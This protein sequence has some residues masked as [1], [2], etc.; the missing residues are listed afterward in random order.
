MCPL[1]SPVILCYIIFQRSFPVLCASL[2][3]G[4]AQSCREASYSHRQYH[5]PLSPEGSK[6]NRARFLFAGSRVEVFRR[7]GKRN[8][9]LLNDSLVTFCSHRKSPCGAYRSLTLHPLRQEG[10]T[11][12]ERPAASHR[13]RLIEKL[14]QF[15]PRPPHTF[16]TPRVNSPCPSPRPVIYCPRKVEHCLR[17]LWRRW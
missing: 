14:P 15:T 3:A 8:P 2:R 1:D 7:R 17:R 13:K 11:P 4:R 16:P 9:R 5:P 12:A 6:G 10:R